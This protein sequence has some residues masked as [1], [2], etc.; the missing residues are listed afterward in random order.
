MIMYQDEII[1]FMEDEL[2]TLG[3]T[4]LKTAQKVREHFM[5]NKGTTCLV[6]NSVCGCAGPDA[7]MGVAEAIVANPHKPDHL[8]TVFYG[9]DKEAI[10][11]L[12]EYI[13]P[14]TVSAPSIGLIKNGDVVFMMERHQIKGRSAEDIG[15]DLMNAIEEHINV[16]PTTTS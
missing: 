14:Y 12:R 9:V 11:E 10:E 13:K 3:F 8:V 5:N 2:K 15:I 7:R 1:A 6:I 16:D 4:P